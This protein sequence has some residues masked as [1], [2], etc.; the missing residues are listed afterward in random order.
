MDFQS[1]HRQWNLE[2]GR[3]SDL[4]KSLLYFYFIV[5]YREDKWGVCVAGGQG[6]YLLM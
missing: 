6:D 3:V 2:G 4:D 1:V 5:F